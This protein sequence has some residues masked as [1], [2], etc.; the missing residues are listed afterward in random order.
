MGPPTWYPKGHFPILIFHLGF[1][2]F[3]PHGTQY[4]SRRWFPL[5]KPI[6]Y[7]YADS[8]FDISHL[9][10]V[11]IPS[12]IP[13]RTHH[14]VNGVPSSC[15]CGPQQWVL[16]GL[17][18]LGQYIKCDVSWRLPWS[19]I[20][21]IWNCWIHLKI[22]TET[23]SPVFVHINVITTIHHLFLYFLQEFHCNECWLGCYTR[24]WAILDYGSKDKHVQA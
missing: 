10:P 17:C 11:G 20:Q 14:G 19:Y 9:G 16:P 5:G 23:T 22:S 12:P 6:R 18:I 7:P 3:F 8:P 1:I 4:W 2:S 24:M 21:L 15:P 13:P